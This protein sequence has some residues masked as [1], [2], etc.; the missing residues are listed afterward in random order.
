MS[1]EPTVVSE[2]QLTGGGRP[3]RFGFWRTAVTI[4]GQT[5]G[6]LLIEPSLYAGQALIRL[7]GQVVAVRNLQAPGIL[8][9]A[10]LVTESG[11]VWMITEEPATPTVAELLAADS[12]GDA[13]DAVAV[14]MWTG[15]TLI[16]LHA[17]GLAHGAFGP[18][19]V[20]L[21]SAGVAALIEVSLKP[22]EI[23]DDVRAWSALL[24]HLADRWGDRGLVRS[25]DI[26]EQSGIAVALRELGKLEQ[27]ASGVESRARL[28]PAPALPASDV[29]EQ[30]PPA[31][32]EEPA[33]V[34][35]PV[36]EAT[37][38]VASAAVGEA[39]VLIPASMTSAATPVGPAPSRQLAFP[40]PRQ[41][42]PASSPPADGVPPEDPDDVRLRFGTGVPSTLEE[43]WRNG[44]LPATD[45]RKRRWRKVIGTLVTCAI[46]GGGGGY[47][48]W[49]YTHPLHISSVR[50]SPTSPPD[51]ACDITVDVVGTVRTNGRPGT[52][53]YQWLRSDGEATEELTQSVPQGVTSVPLHLKWR[54]VGQGN[55]I[56]KATLK[57]KEPGSKVA[58]SEF[59]YNCQ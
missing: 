16:T 51:P 3:G 28:A 30:E 36:E 14:A 17:A 39:T 22:A 6:A 42:A 24:R 53:R 46:L 21:T 32:A 54:F 27:S 55:Y 13:D 41:A 8:P 23:A 45:L 2:L 26:A 20:V 59:T 15:Q 18:Q 50:V 10:D 40:A 33:V 44:P 34:P 19:S 1:E 58:T 11:R 38:M 5:R 52:I 43:V 57:I 56:A 9:I 12:T 49:Y 35:A 7:I 31:H 48:W 29:L 25:A 4:D 37:V 47:V